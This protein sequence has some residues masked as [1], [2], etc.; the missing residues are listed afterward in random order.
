M[1]D[2]R[3]K[4][5]RPTTWKEIAV[6]VGV[7]LFLGA[8][9]CVVGYF[10]SQRPYKNLEVAIRFLPALKA[11]ARDHGGQY[12]RLLLEL[13]PAYLPNFGR[14]KYRSFESRF[15]YDW[16]YIP[17]LREDSPATWIV[18]ASPTDMVKPYTSDHFRIAVFNDGHGEIIPAADFDHR[19]A[20]QVKAMVAQSP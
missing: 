15:S 19:L 6:A 10:N 11:Y 3:I 16:I 12:P 4:L 2:H 7:L 20:R 13:E 9:I 1:N 8:L 17:G 18:L 5:R 14:A